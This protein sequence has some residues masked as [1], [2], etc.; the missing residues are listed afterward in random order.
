MAQTA[1]I[2]AILQVNPLI[3]NRNL[4]KNR[5]SFDFSITGIIFNF[6]PQKIKKKDMLGSNSK[7]SQNIEQDVDFLSTLGPNRRG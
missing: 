3:E 6:L 1:F 4:A 2:K 7:V 5:Q